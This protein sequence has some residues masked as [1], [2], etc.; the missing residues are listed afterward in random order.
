M[1]SPRRTVTGEKIFAPAPDQRSRW[2]K[3]KAARHT[4]RVTGK[5]CE[6]AYRCAYSLAEK[7]E[8]KGRHHGVGTMADRLATCA[9]A[10]ANR[11]LRS[12]CHSCPRRTSCNWKCWFRERFADA[13][14][15]PLSL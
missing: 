10:I 11:Y 3:D 13:T 6:Y 7:Q 8:G 4:R 9:F 14:P 1:T 2:W 15:P 5:A 12:D